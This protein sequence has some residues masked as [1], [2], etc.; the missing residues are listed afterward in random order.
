MASNLA[1]NLGA[2]YGFILVGLIAGRF[3]REKRE[4][5]VGVLTKV[6]IVGVSPLQIFI[7]VTTTSLALTPGLVAQVVLVELL[8]VAILMSTSYLYL[9]RQFAREDGPRGADPEV[10]G[11]SGLSPEVGG[12]SGLAPEVVGRA[13]EED[14]S[15]GNNK[16]MGAFLLLASFPNAMLYPL[17]IV[18]ALFPSDLVLIL[19]IFSTM[20]LLV[21]GTLGTYVSERLG[22]DVR[23]DLL[24][25]VGKLF[26]FPPFLTIVVSI[27]IVAVDVPLPTPQLLAVKPAVNLLAT[28]VGAVLV[29]MILAGLNGPDLRMYWPRVKM[30][31]LWRFGIAA[32]Y[33]MAV[34]YFLHF[35][36]FQTEI[37]TILLLLV[38]G[39]PAVFNVA[40]AVHFKLERQLAAVSVATI[41][42]L[43]LAF[44]PLVILFGMAV[45]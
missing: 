10:G 41:T 13:G 29:G 40:Y 43:A 15:S 19:I 20:A 26:A 4:R 27:V 5:T 25:T 23:P 36:E 18:L 42:L 38:A 30:V 45:F 9:K 7:T 1:V 14:G 3:L 44:L 31:G 21:R 2:L 33:F 17:P 28:A 22:A 6:V 24:S 37:R 11:T 39:P 16:E 8:S 34:V 35:D 32:A 12:T